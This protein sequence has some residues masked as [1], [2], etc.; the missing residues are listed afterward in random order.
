MGPILGVSFFFKDFLNINRA[1]LELAIF[2]IPSF[3]HEIFGSH[4]QVVIDSKIRKN[5][6]L[7]APLLFSR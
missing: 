2:I 3:S 5:A 6:H 7:Y 4:H 1:L